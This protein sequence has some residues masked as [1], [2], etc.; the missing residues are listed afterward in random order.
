M[1]VISWRQ[2]VKMF[3]LGAVALHCR[4]C[5]VE[6]ADQWYAKENG[7]GPYCEECALPDSE[8]LIARLTPQ[9]EY[10]EDSAHSVTQF[11]S[12]TRG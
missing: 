7:D 8:N 10:V 2:A 9:S 6:E 1:I 12:N 11:Y 5:K 4:V 3:R